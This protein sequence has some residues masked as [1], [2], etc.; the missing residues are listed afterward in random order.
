[1]ETTRLSQVHLHLAEVELWSETPALVQWLRPCCWWSDCT[2]KR[3]R[4][5]K[6]H[7]SKMFCNLIVQAEENSEFQKNVSACLEV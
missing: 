7:D 6:G 2:R 3:C 4:G 5:D 1:M